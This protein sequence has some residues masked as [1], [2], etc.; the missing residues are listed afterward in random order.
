M[1][2]SGGGGQYA[3]QGVTLVLTANTRGLNQALNNATRNLNNT[4][5]AGEGL[6][7]RI[8]GASKGMRGF[9]SV[10]GGMTPML[11]GMA[12]PAAAVGVAV[13]GIALAAKGAVTAFADFEQSMAR[14]KA[15]SNAT[16]AEFKLMSATAKE[17]GRTT[18]FTANEAA[19]GLVFLGQAGL[20]ATEQV[21]ALPSVL[22]AAIVG[23]TSL[24]NAAD[25]VT[26]VM[27]PFGIEAENT[28]RVVDVMSSTITQSNTDFNQLAQAMS[29]AAPVAHSAG[30]SLE[31][32][33]AIMG[34]LGNAGLQASKAGTGLRGMLAALLDPTEKAR[35]AM[36]RMGVQ[37]EDANGVLLP[38]EQ[39]FRNLADA[40]LGG[41]EA[42]QIFGRRQAAAAIVVTENYGEVDKLTESLN[43]AGGT[44]QRIADEQMDTFHGSMTLLKSAVNGVAIELGAQLAP[45]IRKVADGI[46]AFIPVARDAL[47]PVIAEMARIWK[48][49]VKPAVDEV[50]QVFKNDLAP[51]LMSIGQT[52]WPYLKPILDS[53]IKIFTNNI[54]GA[55]TVVSQAISAVAAL[56][57]GDFSGAWTAI[58]KLVVGVLNWIIGSW[59]ATLGKLFGEIAPLSLTGF[60]N[61]FIT[62]WNAILT[63]VE[64]VMNAVITAYNATLAKLPGYA[65]VDMVAFADNL[66]VAKKAMTGEEDS[67]ASEAKGAEAVVSEEFDQIET[68]SGEM[69]TEVNEQTLATAQSLVDLAAK[70]EEEQQKFSE[71]MAE[72]AQEN[73]DAAQTRL[74]KTLEGM[75]A[76]EDEYERARIRV[77]TGRVTWNDEMMRLAEQYNTD[78]LAMVYLHW[79]RIEAT[80]KAAQEAREKAH[81][82]HLEKLNQQSVEGFERYQQLTG[83]G[84]RVAGGGGGG[85]PSG[86]GGGGSSRGSNRGGV[87]RGGRLLGVQ[88]LE[89]REAF[90]RRRDKAFAKMDELMKAYTEGE[91]D[92]GTFMA[93]LLTLSQSD[94][95]LGPK[96]RFGGR[97]GQQV[98]LGFSTGIEGIMSFI[99]RKAGID[100]KS[101]TGYMRGGDVGEDDKWTVHH[102]WRE[103]IRRR[104]A[105]YLADMRKP[106]PEPEA[107]PPAV[108]PGAD[109]APT[110]G[111]RMA[112]LDKIL[113]D[114]GLGAGAL[115]SLGAGI[116]ALP[117]GADPLA[118]VTLPSARAATLPSGGAMR[119]QDIHLSAT[120]SIGEHEFA[121]V[122]LSTRRDLER[123]GRL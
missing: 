55:F 75:G 35:K 82:A 63:G 77:K 96:G 87:P 1:T 57:R 79:Q 28:S 78:D 9:G 24:A 38:A 16:D 40:G 39:I 72:L 112:G 7:R 84:T 12:G 94:M 48:E 102:N 17:M 27:L 90:E 109:D 33:S 110:P 67:L 36:Q 51:A 58:Q 61:A 76:T 8:G 4:G 53:L 91:M 45:G 92:V 60:Q 56:L 116:G 80:E 20:T 120:I 68:S 52:V 30:L 43:G 97:L 104:W 15:V 119:A 74:E 99:M 115:S 2:M 19:Q 113:E 101:L 65:A 122:W 32:T 54:K 13:G 6:Q 11:A 85:G 14:A 31:R 23:N 117:R 105:K 47:Q 66:K 59:N 71:A 25:K 69:A 41:A 18:A 83:G 64:T 50:W 46:T 26:N 49:D 21:N 118:G 5:K 42:F 81:K 34:V 100:T 123:A 3:S 44:A 88:R 107:P 103:I 89:S 106:K 62:A 22:N 114:A 93:E 98:N 121:D 111:D 29:Y 95:V 86:G 10:M 70:A 108:T 73:A 37:F